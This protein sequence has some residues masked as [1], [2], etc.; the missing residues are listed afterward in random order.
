MMVSG[1]SLLEKLQSEDKEGFFKLQHRYANESLKDFVT[2]KD[3]SDTC[4]HF[5]K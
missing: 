3:E 2:N 4:C 1:K 5:Q